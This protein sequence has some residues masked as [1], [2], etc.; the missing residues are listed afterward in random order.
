MKTLVSSDIECINEFY[1]IYTKFGTSQE[2]CD[3]LENLSR[4]KAEPWKSIF[5]GLCHWLK[6]DGIQEQTYD[7]REEYKQAYVILDK[8][9]KEIKD[10]DGLLFLFVEKYRIDALSLSFTRPVKEIEKLFDE[11]I[12]KFKVDKTP[13]I[14]AEVA[15]AMLFKSFMFWKY[16]QK[17]EAQ[18]FSS[19]QEELFKRSMQEADTIIE[20]YKADEYK[21]NANIQTT[22]AKTLMNRVKDLDSIGERTKE[23]SNKKLHEFISNYGQSESQGVQT[24]VAKA[25]FKKAWE[26]YHK[27]IIADAEIKNT[28]GEP[29]RPISVQEVIDEYEKLKEKYQNTFIYEIQEIILSSM[30]Y[31]FSVYEEAGRIKDAL[32]LYEGII[33]YYDTHKTALSS[34]EDY[35]ENDI[36]KKR[37]ELQE[38]LKEE[39]DKKSKEVEWARIKGEIDKLSEFYPDNKK[40]IEDLAKLICNGNIVPFA[41]AGLSHFK[42]DDD[43][44]AY[45]LWGD[46]INGIYN[47]YMHFGCDETKSKRQRLIDIEPK[48]KNETCIGKATLLKD[49]L[50]QALFVREVI[51]IFKIQK[52]K[53]EILKEK[54]KQQPYALF[55]LLFKKFIL[56]T[57]FDCLIEYAYQ[58]GK[59]DL[60]S[61]SAYDIN[62]MDYIGN[63][64][65]ILY[66]IH[67]TI[68][69]PNTI[70]LTHEDYKEHYKPDSAN[71]RILNKFL[72]GNS[73]LFMG[74]SL[75]EDEDIMPFYSPVDNYALYPC[76]KEEI[77]RAER[78]ISQKNIIPILFPADEYHYIGSILE[79]CLFY[80]KRE[81]VRENNESWG[82]FLA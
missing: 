64:N 14:Q 45:P 13:E 31:Q 78:R 33:N 24:E 53:T 18:G 41:G 57:N 43:N 65:A 39:S 4:E 32:R 29:K 44:Y 5:L 72:K 63:N 34:W 38:Q 55:P 3:C 70:I 76:S 1:E 74:C 75:S 77:E 21:D 81:K 49:Q 51:D 36:K 82:L 61:C 48:F 42:V 27:K 22:I 50:G 67:G 73:I 40:H 69:Q 47:K 23:D 19:Q 68:E 2:C 6:G 30:I 54:I 59:S 20:T 26:L 25:M 35:I 52:D 62:K 10:R 46:L 37:K 15:K 66:K 11:I 9:Q 12:E 8:V 16:S 58:E 17:A 28:M 71:V 56:T 79:Y 80:N 7:N 60:V